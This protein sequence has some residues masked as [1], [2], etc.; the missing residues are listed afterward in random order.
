MGRGK[1]RWML[2]EER[3]LAQGL[4]VT[5]WAAAAC[6]VAM[7]PLC[8]ELGAGALGSIA[9]NAM[10]I[11]CV[12]AAALWLLAHHAIVDGQLPAP[13]AKNARRSL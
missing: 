7:R 13:K 2:A 4:P 1:R 5:K 8:S 9:G 11:T 3:L 12:A 6:G 10:H